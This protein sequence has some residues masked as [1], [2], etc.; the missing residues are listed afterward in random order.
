M[1]KHI[2]IKQLVGMGAAAATLLA[3]A[4][5]GVANAAEDD[6]IAIPATGTETLDVKAPASANSEVDGHTFNAV[7][8]GTYDAATEGATAGTIKNISVGTVD[9][10]T[11]HTIK[12]AT[13]D[14]LV[15]AKTHAGVATTPATGF[16]GNPVGEIGSMTVWQNTGAFD[17]SGSEILRYVMTTL[18]G[19]SNFQGLMS[20]SPITTTY[21]ATAGK[22]EFTGLVPGI[23][24]IEDMTT[25]NTPSEDTA[26]SIPMLVDTKITTPT[27]TWDHIGTNTNVLGEVEM[28]VGPDDTI[29]KKII[30][31]NGSTPSDPSHPQVSVG[32]TI[33][34]ELD[35]HVPLTTGFAN[36]YRFY[37]SD[38]TTR[39]GLQLVT[40]DPDDI[41][42]SVDNNPIAATDRASVK[43]DSTTGDPVLDA[44]GNPTY[45]NMT[46]TTKYTVRQ[47]FWK[48]GSGNVLK[49]EDKTV[50]DFSPSIKSYAYKA[51]IVITYKMK[52][53][54]SE[55]N[56]DTTDPLA[57]DASVTTST[58]PHNPPSGPNVCVPTQT[59]PCDDGHTG[60]HTT[61][62]SGLDPATRIILRKA[63][64]QSQD[65]STHANLPGGKLT[66]KKNGRVD[67]HFMKLGD[68]KY[69]VVETG[70]A[71]STDEVEA[72]TAQGSE[73]QLMISGLG[74]YTYHV[75]TVAA[76]A[77]Y[78]K[79]D[80]EFDLTMQDK[81]NAT[82]NADWAQS[83]FENTSDNWGMVAATNGPTQTDSN[84]PIIV[85]FARS[86]AN[87]PLTGGA[88]AILGVIVAVILIGAAAGMYVFRKRNIDA[89]KMGNAQIIK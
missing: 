75:A 45:D 21:S 13:A 71:G 41:T 83:W 65:I 25:A 40:D 4:P 79:V 58:D 53:L 63:D 87:L 10:T 11:D 1:R 73:G 89:V 78:T 60:T 42:A 38:K 24:V 28:K 16:N 59:T 3:L 82:S 18:D 43:L 46:A 52:V 68:G 30:K 77:D 15:A 12:N 23:Y 81:A 84:H 48:D 86:L 61:D 20:S 85:N 35:S 32:D 7:R 54:G 8:I 9:S 6:P 70:T 19:N 50:F 57:N 39:A 2:G 29:S 17:D 69:K 26:H 76:P 74:D 37:I 51:P 44:S 66:F 88:G 22:A 36:N 56:P 5:F 34:F 27:A 72:S 49:S 33:T 67:V 80:T 64:F 14:A 31:I 62:P 55:I 47:S